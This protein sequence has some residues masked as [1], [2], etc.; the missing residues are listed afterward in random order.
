MQGVAR[1]LRVHGCS[2]EDVVILHSGVQQKQTLAELVMAAGVFFITISKGQ[3]GGAP[4][5]Q[6]LI[7][8]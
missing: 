6:P 1:V 5:V 3:G 8:A 2:V 7:A 4:L